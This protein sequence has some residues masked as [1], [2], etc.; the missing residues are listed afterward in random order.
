MTLVAITNTL[1]GKKETIVPLHPKKIK[2]YVC[3]I[4]PYDLPHLGHGRCYVVF[5]VVY[6]LFRALGYE[7]TYCRNF[8]DIDDKLLQK[9]E[10]EFGDPLR[11]AEVAERFI[12]AFHEDMG[13]LNC[14][15][16]DNEPRVTENIPEIIEFIKGLIDKGH[17]YE[18]SGDVY[19]SIDSFP[20]YGELSKRNI[21]DL[22]AGA[23]VEVSR[24][25]KNPL[26]FAL[27]KS[28]AEGKFWKSP[29]G[30]GRPGWHIECSALA[31]KFLGDQLDVHGGGMDLIFP[32]HENEKAQSEG[33]LSE[34]F[35]RYWVHNAF[36]TLNTEK[37]SKSVG[38]FFTLRTVFEKFDPMVVRY[39]FLNHYFRAPLDF[40]FDDLEASKKS[41]QRLCRIFA[42]VS[43]A[44]SL[45]LS[46]PFIQKMLSFVLDDLNTVGMFGI[47]FENLSELK[48][49]KALLAQVK[50]FIT[51]ILGLTLEVLPEKE[52]KITPEIEQLINERETA[53]LAK[54]WQRADEL[55]DQ[56]RGLGVEVRDQKNS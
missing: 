3:G 13:A 26:D 28:E 43:P 50:K 33:L 31:K 32:H 6:R 53:R 56:L 1:S 52:V 22:M 35:V 15:S 18:S 27:W 44:D 47:L 40:S 48:N 14:L 23:R 39:Y 41:Y 8:T 5:D 37:M 46:S 29:W 21:A 11:Y 4:T 16:P 30:Y 42:E 34:Q 20:A 19:F 2:M 17:A 45:D 12:R 49:D 38:N 54:N 10:L 7:V 51:E 25:K 55:R 24:L 36:I 9:A